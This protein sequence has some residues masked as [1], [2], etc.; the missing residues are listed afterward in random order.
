MHNPLFSIVIPTFNRA[1]FIRKTVESLL[2]QE[3]DQ[4]EIIVVDDGSTDN[5]KEVIA[6]IKSDKV[7][8]HWKSNAERGAARNYGARLAK[9]DYINFFDSD[10]VAYTNHLVEASR[11]IASLR[12]PEMV[13]LAYDVRDPDGNLLRLANRL[14]ARINDDLVGGN[15]LSCNGVFLRKDIAW[16]WPFSENRLLSA[17]EDYALWMK[18]ASRYDVNCWNVVTSTVVNHEQRSVLTINLEKLLQRMAA[19]RRELETDDAFQKK[20][21]HRW[22]TFRAYQ[23][24]YI[25]LHLGM[26]N[27]SKGKSMP[28]LWNAIILRPQIILTRRFAGAL[29][30]ILL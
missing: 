15:H 18:L 13:H 9:G 4:Y 22:K 28:Y 20:Y 7:H 27:Y 2:N 5:T 17:S 8:Y 30:N 26:A 16:Q 23:N 10:D 12:Q 25:A 29:K 21:G 14:P 1:T 11:A 3:Y 6:Q 19:L 24:I